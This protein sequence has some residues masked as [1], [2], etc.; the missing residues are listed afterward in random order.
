MAIA[1]K[2]L[3]CDFYRVEQLGLLK[4]KAFPNFESTTHSME[5]TWPVQFYDFSSALTRLVRIELNCYLLSR[6]A[7]AIS[8]D[9]LLLI[10]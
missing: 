10:R 2:K 4:L 7:V 6:D 9:L 1:I 3:D 8:L 5:K